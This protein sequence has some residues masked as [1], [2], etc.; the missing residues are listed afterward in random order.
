MATV[1]T[2]AVVDLAE[3][4][5]RALNAELHAPTAAAY[6]VRNPRGAHALASDCATRC[7]STSAGT[8]ATTARG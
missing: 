6:E 1:V 7:T 2:A 3:V 4:S 5:T 8:P